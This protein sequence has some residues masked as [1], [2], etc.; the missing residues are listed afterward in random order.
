VLPGLGAYLIVQRYKGASQ[1]GSIGETD[2]EDQPYP[3]SLPTSPNGALSAITYR[4]A[5]RECTDTGNGPIL[6]AC[7]L[8]EGPPL[9]PKP[10]PN[11]HVPIA[12]HLRVHGDLIGGGEIAFAAPYPI[13]SANQSY[14]VSANTCHGFEGGEGSGRDLADRDRD[15]ARGAKVSISVGFLLSSACTQTV[16]VKVTYVVFADDNLATTA[17]GAVTIHEPPGTHAVPLP[18]PSPPRLPRG[19]RRGAGP[20]GGRVG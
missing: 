12:V 5:G 18:R 4:Y 11:V 19:D 13:T 15:I 1:L 20:H 9:R 8:S 6:R 7:G 10:L 16:T 2:G 14:Y 3:H 17:V